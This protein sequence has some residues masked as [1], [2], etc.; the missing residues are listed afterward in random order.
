I[1]PD[2]PAERISFML[3][4]ARPVLVL[5][6][7]GL[8]GELACPEGVAV[9]ALDDPAAIAATRAMP[10]H[11]P[12]DADR[13][14][15]LSLAHPAYLIYTS[16]STGRPKAVVVSHAGLASFSAAEVDHFAVGPGDRVL[17]F[18][19]P[20]FDASVLE[21]CMSLPA[22][23][24]LVVPPPGPLLGEVLAEVLARRGVT[25]ALIPPSALA[26]VPDAVAGEGLPAFQTLIVGGEACTAAL[27]GRWA[28]GR[29]LIN[30]YG[31]TEATV[32]AT[33][34]QPL[35][36]GGP[37]PIGRPIANTRA[38]VLDAAL[39]PVP[40]GVPGELYIAGA[41]LARGYLKRPG[42]TAERFVA[43]PFGEGGSR[44]YRTGD[45]VRWR[46]D[47]VIDYLGRADDQVKIRGFRI[48]LGEVESA[49]R[50][51]PDVAEGVVIA[52]EDE[53]G[54]KR[55]VAY[56]VPVGDG[57]APDTP[58]L[59][60]F[61][62][63][64]L[65]DYMVPSAFVTLD[66]L[67]LSPNGKLDRKALPAPDLGAGVAGAYVAPRTE[68]EAVLAGIWAEVLGV[69]GVGVEDNFFELGGDSILSIQVVSRARR[70]GLALMPRDL[71]LHR[72][73]ASLAANV[74]DASQ[75]P[76]EQGPVTGAAP[77]TPIQHWFFEAQ[78]E[79]PERFDQSVMIEL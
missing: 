37:P 36:P 38:Y 17:Q 49:L 46:P 2:Y 19:S 65:P 61:L 18:S 40:P 28:P 22:G 66:A 74:A 33:W 59:R 8:A 9:L 29:R 60:R 26:T 76:A 50:Q 44:M 75:Q 55:L 6:L 21:L 52:R 72:T 27:V 64:T 20:S 34:S 78:P 24:A 67:P 35:S 14:R 16:G 15:P 13:S 41:G 42:L 32:V 73:V 70:A 68:A 58:A 63:E 45:L 1:D 30:A 53:P 39:R 5:T 10:S 51:H 62:A 25:H 54:H 77:P 71:F 56:L 47:G 79:A 11:A 31:P 69:D 48:E 57:E 43:N 4:D 12:T 23:A 3:D 7:A